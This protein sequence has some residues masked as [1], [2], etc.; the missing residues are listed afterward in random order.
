MANILRINWNEVVQ[1]DDTI[2]LL[3][4]LVMGR[5]EVTLEWLKT[6]YG[7]K[8]FVP[9]NHD[10]VWHNY[11]K[12]REWLSKYHDAGIELILP[13]TAQAQPSIMIDHVP[14]VMSH[15]P[16]RNAGGSHGANDDRYEEVRPI[17]HGMWLLC[18]HVHDFWKQKGR[19]INVGTDVWGYYPVSEH[20]IAEMMTIGAMDRVNKSR[21]IGDEHLD[22]T[23]EEEEEEVPHDTTA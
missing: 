1:P 10:K 5:R 21:E 17:D 16:Y 9:G 6:V 3:G 14:V 23:V 2:Y 22:N 19:Q 18:G 20:T 7:R 8:I 4:D 12:W 11:G 13:S 15:L